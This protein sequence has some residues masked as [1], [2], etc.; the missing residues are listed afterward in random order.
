MQRQQGAEVARCLARDHILQSQG[1]NARD[2]RSDCSEGPLALINLAW[3][4]KLERVHTSLFTSANKLRWSL[5]YFSW[6]VNLNGAVTLC[7]DVGQAKIDMSG[8]AIN[9]KR[10]FIILD[11]IS[12]NLPAVGD[13][14]CVRNKAT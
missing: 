14:N 6:A 7:I 3:Q 11:P 1:Y 10:S 12:S 8:Q 13:D 5:W 9:S 2:S 4:T